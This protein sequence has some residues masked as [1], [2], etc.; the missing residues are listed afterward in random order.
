M[1]DSSKLLI[2]NASSED[3]NIAPETPIETCIQ[4]FKQKTLAKALD[5]LQTSLTNNFNCCVA[6]ELGLVT[7]L[8]SGHFLRD[9]EDSPSNFSFF[10]APKK[11]P[12][13]AGH[14]QPTM[15]LHLKA[16]QGKGWSETDMK[17]ALKQGIVTPDCIHSFTHQLR[18]LWALS[19]FFFGPNS[20]LSQRLTPMMSV[21][22]KY[23]LTFEGA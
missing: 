4:F 21:L 6:I 11:Q 10:L 19:A 23:T 12:L 8:Y 17:E 18:N 20:I 13:S 15:I 3:G 5:F 7:A 9:R 22:A 16:S 2:L 14:F 1:H